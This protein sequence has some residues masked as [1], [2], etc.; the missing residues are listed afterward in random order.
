MNDRPESAEKRR[1]ANRFA[2][3][4]GVLVLGAAGALFYFGWKGAREARRGPTPVTAEQLAAAPSVRDLPAAWVTLT[5]TNIQD[6]SVRRRL[7]TRPT[8]EYA[9]VRLGGRY[10]VVESYA[11]AQAGAPLTGTLQAWAGDEVARDVE[12]RV[13]ACHGRLL[14]FYLRAQERQAGEPRALWV[15]AGLC[16]LVGLGLVAGG[17]VGLR[18][19]SASARRAE[20]WQAAPEP[21]VYHTWPDA[22]M[23][24]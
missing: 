24:W 9:V 12:A 13:P 5:P 19:A 2:V 4:I 1:S 10:L 23:R 7:G 21:P 17:L 22:W 8:L 11:T 15:G 3:A 6:T 20:E 18:N 16:V 14:P